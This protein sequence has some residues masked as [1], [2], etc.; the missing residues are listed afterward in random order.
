MR[1]PTIVVIL[2]WSLSVYANSPFQ[3]SRS[4][5]GSQ[6]KQLYTI[7]HATSHMSGSSLFVSG[8]TVPVA[9]RQLNSSPLPKGATLAVMPRASMQRGQTESALTY[10]PRRVIINDGD[11]GDYGDDGDD[12]RPG[13]D[14]QDP[15]TPV[16]DIPLPLMLLFACLFLLYKLRYE[17][18]RKSNHLA[19]NRKSE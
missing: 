14:P 4:D 9:A 13:Y 18:Y 6:P 19:S 2:L 12:P 10:R 8:Y 3:S 1:A 11:D 16:G 15:F 5:N 17:Q 7:S